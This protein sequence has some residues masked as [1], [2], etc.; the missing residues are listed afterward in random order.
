MPPNMP[1]TEKNA[2]VAALSR[3]QSG[4]TAKALQRGVTTMPQAM[5][6]GYGDL[7]AQF[8]HLTRLRQKSQ[9]SS[10]SQQAP[11]SHTR[12]QVELSPQDRQPQSHLAG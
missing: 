8:H 9:N 10:P 12:N 4:G 6:P 1:P 3:P 5:K 2:S 7:L 11:P